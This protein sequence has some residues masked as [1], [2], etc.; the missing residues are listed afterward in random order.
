MKCCNNE[1]IVGIASRNKGENILHEKEP[2][3]TKKKNI[4]KRQP[5][6]KILQQR[7]TLKYGITLENII[8]ML[9][10]S[11]TNI[12]D[13]LKIAIKLK[14]FGKYKLHILFYLR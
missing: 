3:I 6:D 7:Y 11:Q 13:V 8:L 5:L 1:T 4:S 9:S 12:S 2:Y 10:L 14:C